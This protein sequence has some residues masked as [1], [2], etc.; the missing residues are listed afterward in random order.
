MLKRRVSVS[1]GMFVG[2]LLVMNVAMG[3]G[4]D[5]APAHLNFEQ[6]STVVH[7]DHVSI[8][9]TL[10]WA[11]MRWVNAPA[12]DR[13]VTLYEYDAGA[14][15]AL[16]ACSESGYSS[17]HALLVNWA[18]P[19]TDTM[20]ALADAGVGLNSQ[21]SNYSEDLQAALG[22]GDWVT[23]GNLVTTLASY[24]IDNQLWEGRIPQPSPVWHELPFVNSCRLQE[25]VANLD[26]SALAWQPV[27][28]QKLKEI[29]ELAVVGDGEYAGTPSVI[30]PHVIVTKA[31]EG[32]VEHEQY[33][34][35]CWDVAFVQSALAAPPTSVCNMELN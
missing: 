4:A 10:K 9:T 22:G 16:E 7:S 6:F 12:A 17:D 34:A 25:T 2:P 27:L 11:G 5:Q 23:V 15:T 20:T 8:L 21:P 33:F 28:D 35:E 31:I 14:I 1:L 19:T 3:Q 18:I 13:V 24:E 26:D 32:P 30:S 29:A